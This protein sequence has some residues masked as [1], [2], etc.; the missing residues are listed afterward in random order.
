M[1]KLDLAFAVGALALAGVVGG[2]L[3]ALYPEWFGGYT[4]PSDG[5]STASSTYTSTDGIT[6]TPTVNTTAT[7]NTTST[8]DSASGPQPSN[9]SGY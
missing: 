9:N 7:Q 6:S 3:Y 8:A 2:L 5:T 1:E 4:E